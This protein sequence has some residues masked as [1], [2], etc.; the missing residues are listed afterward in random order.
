MWAQR[1]DTIIG[2]VNLPFPNF[3]VS[4]GWY[5]PNLSVVKASLGLDLLFFYP[6]VSCQRN[7]IGVVGGQ[8]KRN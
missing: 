5:V 7:A 2:R 8:K 4:G 3:H 1:S 6:T